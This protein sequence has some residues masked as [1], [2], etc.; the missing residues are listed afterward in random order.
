MDLL[1]RADC[2]YG[3]GYL[4]CRPIPAVA[5]EQWGNMWEPEQLLS[6]GA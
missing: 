6:I 2:D 1:R 3:Q 4:F 5:F